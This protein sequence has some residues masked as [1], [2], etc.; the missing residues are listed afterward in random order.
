MADYLHTCP[1][2]HG[3]LTK[4]LYGQRQDLTA[5]ERVSAR[6]RSSRRFTYEDIQQIAD[7]PHW[8]PRKFWR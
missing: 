6:I 5:V 3:D 8:N 7:S 1:G 4:L 2:L